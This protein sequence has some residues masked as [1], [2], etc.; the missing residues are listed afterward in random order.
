[1][2]KMDNLKNKI[3]FENEHIKIYNAIE[4]KIKEFFKNYLN[5]KI[6]KADGD[7]IKEIKNNEKLNQILETKQYLDLIKPLRQNDNV[8]IHLYIK[9][10][11][12]TIK[13]NIKLCFSGGSYETNDY[14]CKYI[15]Y[16]LYIGETEKQIL[17]KIYEPEQKKEIN[18]IEQ[19]QLI[20]EYRKKEKELRAIKEKIKYCLFQYI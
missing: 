14:Y 5:K 1:M 17:K 4:P 15:D 9:A 6:I 8:F 20:D 13:V 3:Y 10:Q 12:S 2:E 11:Y 7:L 18:Y 19:N 16:Y